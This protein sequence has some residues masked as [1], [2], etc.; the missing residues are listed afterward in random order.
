MVPP[1]IVSGA[2]EL[3]RIAEVDDFSTEDNVIVTRVPMKAGVRT[4]HA[5]FGDASARASVVGP[6]AGTGRWPVRVIQ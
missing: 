2:G 6:A 5:R 3:Q 4:L 1:T